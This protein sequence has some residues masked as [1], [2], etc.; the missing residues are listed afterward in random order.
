MT[1]PLLPPLLPSPTDEKADQKASAVRPSAAKGEALCRLGDLSL[2][3]GPVEIVRTL[4]LQRDLAATWESLEPKSFYSRYGRR[5]FDLS[6]LAVF[7]VPAL[8]IGALIFTVNLVQFRS[9]RKV[10]FLQERVGYR[11]QIFSIIKFR[12]MAEVGEN[13]FDSWGAGAEKVRV[14]RV[15]RLLR[16]THLDELPQLINVA[17]GE[18]A[19]VGP[20]PEM[21]EIET[22]AASVVEGFTTRLAVP[23]GISGYA[24]I[25]QGYTGHDDEAYAEKFRVADWYRRS[26]CFSLDLKIIALTLVWMV[27]GRGWQW[28]QKSVST[29]VAFPTEAAPTEAAPSDD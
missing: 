28:N 12:T 9:L 19:F 11:G 27:R 8:A 7:G 20:R 5:L 24:Q 29:G 17:R 23:P 13:H 2:D 1:A 22:W 16:N 3:A 14:T 18:M 6:L 25:T 21:V 15:G 26:Q 10:F 4:A